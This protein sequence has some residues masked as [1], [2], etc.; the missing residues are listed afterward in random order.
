M[1]RWKSYFATRPVVEAD[2]HRRRR[3]RVDRSDV[4]SLELG[5]AAIVATRR[6]RSFGPLGVPAAA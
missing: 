5:E 3:P 6:R 1:T 2:R 4:L